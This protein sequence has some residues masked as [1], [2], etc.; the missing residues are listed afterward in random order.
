M[1]TNPS[2]QAE[3]KEA[4]QKFHGG[5]P[6][7]FDDDLGELGGGG[8][9]GGG[10]LADLGGYGG[11]VGGH[12]GHH[13]YNG[14]YYGGHWPGHG[15]GEYGGGYGGG[16]GGGHYG[17]LNIQTSVAG[18]GGWGGPQYSQPGMQYHQVR[19]RV[20]TS[21]SDPAAAAEIYLLPRGKIFTLGAKNISVT[22][23][24]GWRRAPGHGDHA[25]ARP[26]AHRLQQLALA[27]RVQRGGAGP[28]G[29]RR[30]AGG[31]QEALARLLR[32]GARAPAPRPPRPHHAQ[33]P[34]QQEAQGVQAAEEEGPQRAPE[35]SVGLRA[36]L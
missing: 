13:H 9:Q 14:H 2:C 3:G 11:F 15:H 23:S 22:G 21:A 17:N 4:D 32:A 27:A 6:G 5:G 34:A 25:A 31:P 26:L 24:V 18:G 7:H 20:I 29:H 8:Q 28:G 36:L 16:G 35:A 12:G 1:I 33:R 10:A 30:A 19:C